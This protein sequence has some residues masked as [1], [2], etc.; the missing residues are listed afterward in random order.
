[1]RASLRPVVRLAVPALV[2]MSVSGHASEQRPDGGCTQDERLIATYREVL[3]SA[4]NSAKVA[5]E[6]DARVL[7]AVRESAKNAESLYAKAVENTQA[8]TNTVLWSV[9]AAFAALTLEGA[10]AVWFLIWSVRRA[11]KLLA[12]GEEIEEKYAKLDAQLEAIRRDSKWFTNELRVLQIAQEAP[13]LFGK[14]APDVEDAVNSI[15]AQ[16]KEGTPLVRWLGAMMLHQWR[17]GA[18]DAPQDLEKRVAGIVASAEGI[19]PVGKTG[20]RV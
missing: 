15:T 9:G 2:L 6:T 17:G 11:K 13:R 12:K 20:P 4:R 7:E 14:N 1:M 8:T 3:E 10:G 16:M 19:P 5:Q 18:S